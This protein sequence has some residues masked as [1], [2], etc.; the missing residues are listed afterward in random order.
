MA[1]RRGAGSALALVLACG[2]LLAGCED[3]AAGFSAGI[4][5]AIFLLLFVGL[6]LPTLVVGAVVGLVLWARQRRDRSGRP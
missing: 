4:G 6:V 3:S 1:R 2:V 5:K